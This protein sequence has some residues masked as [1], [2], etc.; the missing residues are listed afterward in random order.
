MIGGEF[1]IARCIKPVSFVPAPD[2]FYYASG[3]SALFQILLSLDLRNRTVWLPDYLC[4]S[5]V[6]AVRRAGYSFV[7]YRLDDQLMTCV[8]DL[9][10]SGFNDGDIVLLIN[11]F[12]LQDLRGVSEGIKDM[13]PAATVV[14]DDVQAL[15]CFL[16]S[17]NPFAD[18]CFTS[19][20][21][22]ISVPDGGLVYTKKTMPVPARGNTFASVKFEAGLMKA[23]RGEAG[24]R[25]EDYL[26]L[27]KKGEELVDEN[28]HGGMSQEGIGLFG[29]T[30]LQAVKRQR[31]KNVRTL[32]SG[33]A[34]L[35][36][37]PML[38]V[39]AEQ[40]PLFIPVFL[41]D[42]DS[43][44]KGMFAHEVFCPVHWPLLDGLLIGRGGMMARHE[45]SLIVDQRYGTDDMVR[46]LELL[47]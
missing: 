1:E 41:S 29:G 47:K 27:F 36:I 14:E 4:G 5:I 17:P 30:D 19:L 32:L 22:W 35:G 43:I 7:F 28:Y 21:K 20:R 25:D 8:K 11:Y 18:Y 13:F 6:E 3:R 33:L 24:V 37:A 2:T 40:V 42:R 10:E 38:E 39:R 23:R 16:E 46:I 34:E 9:A 31:L 26:A 45:L 44:R 12:G 15:F